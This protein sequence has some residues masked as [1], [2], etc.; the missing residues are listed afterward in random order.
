MNFLGPN[1]EDPII[2][3]KRTLVESTTS[4][5]YEL[6]PSPMRKLRSVVRVIATLKGGLKLAEKPTPIFENQEKIYNKV[7]KC[8]EIANNN[9]KVKHVKIKSAK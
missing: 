5:G 7:S 9:N 3:N 6:K 2:E 1:S 8:D 4:L